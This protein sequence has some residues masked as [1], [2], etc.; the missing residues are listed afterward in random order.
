MERFVVRPSGPL[1]GAVTVQGAKNS[2]LKLMA[3]CLL[4]SGSSRLINVPDITDVT[5]MSEVLEAIGA[6]VTREADR[7]LTVHTPEKITPVAPYELVEKMRASVVVLGP[8]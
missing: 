3:A 1:S 7:S 8:L 5:I 6:T 2:A 4:T